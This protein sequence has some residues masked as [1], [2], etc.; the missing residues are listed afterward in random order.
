MN[1][2]V[3]PTPFQNIKWINKHLQEVF[4]LSIIISNTFRIIYEIRT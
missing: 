4:R 1:F 2:Q 3:Q